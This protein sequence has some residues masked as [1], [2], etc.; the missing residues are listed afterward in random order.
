MKNPNLSKNDLRI[1]KYG[2]DILRKKCEKIEKIDE[3]IKTFVNKMKRIMIEKN[4]V[5]LAAPQVGKAIQLVIVDPSVGENPE[6]FLPLI[7]PEII[8]S[9]GEE[10]G[11]EGC[12]SVPGILLQIKRSTNIT[13]RA[14][15]LE[16]KEFTKDFSDFK[17]RVIQHELDHLNGTLIIDK[18][19]SLKRQFVKKEI[20][21]IKNNGEW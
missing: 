4:G 7:N 11:E 2:E 15:D 14:L 8:N 10:S 3:S 18:V 19:S 20:K 9:E 16:G 5:G 13:I 6:E 21:R 17:A 1:Y 12:L